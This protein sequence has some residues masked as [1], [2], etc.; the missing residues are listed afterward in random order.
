MFGVPYHFFVVHF[1]LVLVLLAL[2]YDSRGVYEVGYRLTLGAAAGSLI[3]AAT[4]L[5]LAGGQLSRMTVHASASLIGS[6]A[7]VS[8]A[9]IRY[10]RKAR[11]EEPMTR[12]P[13]VWLLLEIFG[14]GCIVIAA[15]TGH[16]AVLGF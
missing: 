10:S 15:V 16:R 7:V 8:L 14:A 4:G 1:P 3:G 6:L 5:M 12:F 13:T 2:F 11:E 9:M